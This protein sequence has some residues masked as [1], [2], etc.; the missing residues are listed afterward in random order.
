M[1]YAVKFKRTAKGPFLIAGN[2]GQ[3]LISNNKKSMIQHAKAVKSAGAKYVSVI[4]LVK[5]KVYKIFHINKTKGYII[6][7]Y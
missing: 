4:K 2:L 3:P 7:K 6:S 5:G 1:P